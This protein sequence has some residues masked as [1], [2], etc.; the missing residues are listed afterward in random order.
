MLLVCVRLPYVTV[1]VTVVVPGDKGTMLSPETDAI[2]GSVTAHV[3]VYSLLWRRMPAVPQPSV[4]LTFA[5][6]VGSAAE[7]WSI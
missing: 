5:S 1:T 7:A 2:A 4:S 6:T 3:A